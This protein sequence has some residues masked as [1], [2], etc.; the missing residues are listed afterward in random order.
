MKRVLLW[1]LAGLLSVLITLIALFPIA[2]LVPI[3]EAQTQ[4]RISLGD[5]QGTLWNG[6]AFIGSAASSSEPITPLLPGR[7][8]WHISPLILLGSVNADLSN[9]ES[10]SEP[11]HISGNWHEITISNAALNL[12]A[13]RLS[14]LGAPLNTLQ[15]SGQM[16]LSWQG[17]RVALL[18]GEVQFGGVMN[19]SMQNIASR[20]S[21]IKPLGAYNLEFIWHGARADVSLTS[22]QGPLLLAG[23]G[24]FSNGRLHF[25]GNAQAAAGHENELANLLNLL[26]QRGVV[27]GKEVILLQAQ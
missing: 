15:P 21:P 8:N 3:I 2:Y 4:G 12:P 23:K 1:S 9:S 13:A 11:L 26:G 7:F 18:A 27:D 24:D 17:L 16:R 10:L 5:A 6:S 25:S 20:L 19:L 14:S 22:P